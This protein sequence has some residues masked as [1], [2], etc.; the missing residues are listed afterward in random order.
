MPPKPDLLAAAAWAEDILLIFDAAQTAIAFTVETTLHTVHGSFRLREGEIRF[1]PATG[2]ASGQI[3]VDS[4][5]GESGSQ[6][7]DSR[8]HKQVLESARFPAIT[9]QPS[10]VEGTVAMSGESQVRVRGTFGIHG[11]G[12]EIT[13][14]AQ[15]KMESGRAT[16]T[17]HFTVPYTKWGMKNPGNFLLKVKDTAEI[18]IRTVSAVHHPNASRGT[19]P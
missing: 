13:V 14:P 7:R 3:V 1:D 16:A 2:K 6:A 4:T 11:A 17:L 18:E 12:H 10:R 5:T 9:F 15:V 19:G 8:M